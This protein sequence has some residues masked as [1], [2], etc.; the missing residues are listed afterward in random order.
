MPR[1]REGYEASMVCNEVHTLSISP[2]LW[3]THLWMEQRMKISWLMP[4][5]SPHITEPAFGKKISIR[6]DKNH[7]MHSV[8][9]NSKS[10]NPESLQSLIPRIYT[11]SRS[12][13]LDWDR[14]AHD[15]SLYFRPN[16]ISKSISRPISIQ[17]FR[18]LIVWMEGILFPN[19][20]ISIKST[21]P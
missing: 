16:F 6:N 7:T 17:Q 9:C 5:S 18:S 19:Q 10:M 11:V 14:T 1:P 15:L 2:L 21:V 3:H 8:S 12:G 4:S 20:S 13:L